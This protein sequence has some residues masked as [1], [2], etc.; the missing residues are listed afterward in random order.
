MQGIMRTLVEERVWN[1]HSYMRASLCGLINQ[2]R[3]IWSLRDFV[4]TFEIINR[5]ISY[6]SFK[7]VNAL[8]NNLVTAHKNF[9]LFVIKGSSLPLSFFHFSDQLLA[10]TWSWM[11]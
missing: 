8:L 1:I 2:R 11:N 4:A 10:Q 5:K 7:S 3:A 9:N 6:L